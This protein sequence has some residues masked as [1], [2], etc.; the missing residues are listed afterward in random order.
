MLELPGVF[1][2]PSAS[3]QRGG[4]A[5]LRVVTGRGQP[6]LVQDR[7][8]VSKVRLKKHSSYTFACSFH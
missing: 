3:A 1:I 5:I 4:T 6:G 2:R 7:S 8:K